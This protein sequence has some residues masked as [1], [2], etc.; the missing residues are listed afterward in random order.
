MR[1]ALGAGRRS[2]LRLRWPAP[3]LAV[4]RVWGSCAGGPRAR[5]GLALHVHRAS[6]SSAPARALVPL[7]SGGRWRPPRPPKVSFL[8]L[9]QESGY[10][11]R[12][13]TVTTTS[14]HVLR[15][16]QGNLILTAG[17]QEQQILRAS[18]NNRKKLLAGTRG[19]ITIKKHGSVR[20][21][22]L[23]STGKKNHKVGAKSASSQGFQQLD[24]TIYHLDASYDLLTFKLPWINYAAN[25]AG[26]WQL[27]AN[28]LV[29]LAGKKLFRQ[30][31]FN[32]QILS[33]SLVN[34][35]IDDTATGS[36]SQL[37][38]SWVTNYAPGINA[39]HV[40]FLVA[41]AD[42]T[43]IAQIGL[44]M[45]NPAYK[46]N[47]A[48]FGSY[49][50]AGKLFDFVEQ[51]AIFLNYQTLAPGFYDFTVFACTTDADGAPGLQLPMEVSIVI[52]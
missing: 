14:T 3:R 16:K 32:R 35:P 17:A 36:I 31:N 39:A 7:G 25:I 8:P 27:C 11:E 15:T 26:E 1:R 5:H 48:D 46:L 10:T 34:A 29:D 21:P 50:T 45:G 41:D 13:A 37:L 43:A 9:L 44:Q 51:L 33:L 42:K 40:A 4:A 2:A 23:S 24:Q 30:Y 47:V 28:C 22:G 52:Q 20:P 6:G 19:K 49:H 18:T 12:M 38:L